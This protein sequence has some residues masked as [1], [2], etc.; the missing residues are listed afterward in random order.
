MC[1]KLLYWKLLPISTFYWNCLWREL[2]VIGLSS[3][4]GSHVELQTCFLSLAKLLWYYW[5]VCHKNLID[6]FTTQNFLMSNFSVNDSWVICKWGLPEKT[7]FLNIFSFAML[8]FFNNW[9]IYTIYTIGVLVQQEKKQLCAWESCAKEFQVLGLVEYHKIC[10]IWM[11]WTLW[12]SG[13]QP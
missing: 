3:H 2:F 13:I 11:P 7:Y 5:I 12:N 6:L 4:I 1:H 10:Q 8:L 9:N